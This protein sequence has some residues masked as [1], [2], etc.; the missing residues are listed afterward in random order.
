[1]IDPIRNAREEQPWPRVARQRQPAD[2]R[3]NTGRGPVHHRREHIES[4]QHPDKPG[5]SAWP[6]SH[7][8][9]LPPEGGEADVVLAQF[10]GVIGGR[11]QDQCRDNEGQAEPPPAVAQ[12]PAD[13]L[14]LQARPDEQARQEEHGRHEEAVGEQ[15]DAVKAEEGLWIG[16]SVI[17][18]GDDRMVDQHQYRDEG[19]GAVKRGIPRR[20][21]SRRLDL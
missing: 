10:D 1:M 19:S 7:G 14:A 8:D 4:Q 9:R 18:V 2:R 6:R 16:M 20:G 5:R 12:E 15:H 13:P 11:H 17:G 3:D 21:F